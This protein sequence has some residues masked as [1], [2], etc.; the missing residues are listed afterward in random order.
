[1]IRHLSLLFTVLA[2]AAVSA[3]AQSKLLIQ[4]DAS[5]T[6]HLKAY[7]IAY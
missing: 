5:Q 4:M 3:S 7:G 6:D 1:M 2:T